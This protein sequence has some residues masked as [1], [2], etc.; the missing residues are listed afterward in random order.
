M[1]TSMARPVS[2][3]WQPVVD[4][5]ARFDSVL[6]KNDWN[7]TAYLLAEFTHRTRTLATRRVTYFM[8]IC[9]LR[10]TVTTE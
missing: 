10:S 4:L 2:A 9:P 7:L 5:P 1:E 6:P 8:L 3:D